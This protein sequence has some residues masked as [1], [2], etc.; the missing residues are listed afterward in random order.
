[1]VS[2]PLRCARLLYQT[3]C[4]VTVCFSSENGQNGWRCGEYCPAIHN[5]A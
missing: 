1:M 5:T 3:P 2:V 4:I